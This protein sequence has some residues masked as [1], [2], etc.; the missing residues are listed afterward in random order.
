MQRPLLS[1]CCALL[2]LLFPS[3][4]A[5]EEA[6]DVEKV[7]A[8]MASKGSGFD[9]GPLHKRGKEGLAWLLD[10]LLPDT[11]ERS[12]PPATEKEVK[13]LIKRLGD[14]NAKVRQAATD[15]LIRAGRPFRTL[16]EEAA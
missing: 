8:E 9:A 5:A 2:L 1:A 14:E 6:L 16:V 7:L 10:Q 12:G 3:L 13:D 4:A 15:R 11:R